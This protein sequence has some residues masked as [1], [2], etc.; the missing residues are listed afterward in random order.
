MFL[1]VYLIL[2]QLILEFVLKVA[3]TCMSSSNLNML[4]KITSFVYAL[5]L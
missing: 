4:H 2:F 3:E 1:I 5:Y